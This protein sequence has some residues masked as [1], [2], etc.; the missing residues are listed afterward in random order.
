MLMSCYALL[1]SIP[2]PN[3]DE[4]REDID[5]NLCCCGSYQSVVES[6]LATVKMSLEAGHA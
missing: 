5:G 1:L 2:D 6:V 3:P 4:I